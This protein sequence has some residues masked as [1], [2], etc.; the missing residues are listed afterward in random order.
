M[1]GPQTERWVFSSTRVSEAEYDPVAMT[2]N[3]VFKDGTPWQYL[4]VPKGTWRRFKNAPSPGR[5]VN[6]VLNS[7]ESGHQ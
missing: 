4:R 3:V 1:T 6:E 2:L 5:Y 7:Y